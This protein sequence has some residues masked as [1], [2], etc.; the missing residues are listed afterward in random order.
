[1]RGTV[2]TDHRTQTPHPRRPGDITLSGHLMSPAD[3]SK[4][5]KMLGTTGTGKSTAI[6]ELLTGAL[7]RGDRAIIADPD[8][9]YARQFY[10]ATRGDVILNPFDPRAARWDPFAEIIQPHD[11][12]QLA[13][14]LIPDYDG[15]DR[16]WRNY[17]RT[18][19]TAT[20]RQIHRTSER[21]L[22]SLYSV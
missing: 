14:S 3:E 2:I 19:L 8:G 4:H 22:D 7:A 5:F 15:Q 10:D 21:N 20:L 18:F 16:N 6:R 13:R 9:S 1:E 17:A 12:D 11:A